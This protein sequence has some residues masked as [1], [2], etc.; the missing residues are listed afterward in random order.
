MGKINQLLDALNSQFESPENKK[1]LSCWQVD[2]PGIR[3]ETQWHG[4]PNYTVADGRPMPVTV[5][6]Q[7]KIWQE[8]LGLDFKRYFVDPDYYLEYY[9]RMRLA[10]FKLFP[11]DTPLTRDIPVCFGV[12]HEAGLMGQEI[13]LDHGEEPAFSNTPCV[14]DS[15]DFD[16][17][18]DFSDNPFLKM[19]VPFYERI[20]HLVGNEF[21]VIFPI[22]YRGPQGVALYLRGFQEFSLDLY[23]QSAFADRLL[24]YITDTAKAYCTWRADYLEEPIGKGDLFNDDIPLMSPEMYEQ[25]FLPF[26]QEMVDF[27][28][29]VYYWHS[30]G[31]TTKHIS[32]IG[33][34]SDVELLDLGVSILDKKPALEALTNTEQAV[35][36]RVFAQ[37]YVQECSEEEAKRYLLK[38]LAECSQRGLTKYVVRSSG[39]SIVFGADEDI[40]RLARWVDI[41]REAQNEVN[42]L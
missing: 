17:P 19:A 34:L 13:H 20:R 4:V 39:M 38:M 33:K 8:K 3:A 35:E 24:R 10:K 7:D 27:Y 23:F 25:R 36:L 21:N 6:C 12:T 26:E 11:D 15:Y 31:D 22:W 42:Q 32:S 29:G 37:P 9:L 14:S 1:R 40:R 2:Q 16:V 5:E 41:A 30:C 18:I 28:G